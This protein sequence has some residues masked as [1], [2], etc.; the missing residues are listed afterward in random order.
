MHID[1]AH[2][3]VSAILILGTI[4]GLRMIGISKEG[5]RWDWRLFFAIFAVMLAL[6][7]VWPP[8]A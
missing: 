5:R 1:L 2:A 3:L 7:L 8:G 4:T 6:N